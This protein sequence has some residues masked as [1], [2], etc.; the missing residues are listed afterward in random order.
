MKKNEEYSR[1]SLNLRISQ[2]SIENEK[3]NELQTLLK[4]NDFI[5]SS[6]K[7]EIISKDNEL[8]QSNENQENSRKIIENQRNQ[9][10]SIKTE[11]SKNN[12]DFHEISLKYDNLQRNSN[13]ISLKYDTLQRSIAEMSQQSHEL[14]SEN[15]ELKSEL[16][17][18]HE[19]LR[20]LQR[21]LEINEKAY[22]ELLQENEKKLDF[23]ENYKIQSVKEL[24]SLKAENERNKK[25]YKEINEKYESLRDVD[26]PVTEVAQM[27]E[28]MRK[29]DEMAKKAQ[30]EN[31]NL[32]NS[33]DENEKNMQY[34]KNQL[35]ENERNMKKDIEA[36]N[37][38]NLSI[39]QDNQHLIARINE[40]NKENKSKLKV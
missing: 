17:K 39:S 15:N 30:S 36:K 27:K 11:L 10:E 20:N 28:L 6:L 4:H 38:Q 3:I 26:S 31:K 25:N 9:L 13:E 37:L 24:S 29:T 40:I 32:K 1:K 5:T 8:A 12:L 33:L 7:E 34:L 19:L 18:T 21:K 16:S 2:L 22:N 14:S 23:Y 35:E